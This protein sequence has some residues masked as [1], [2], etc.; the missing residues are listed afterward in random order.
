MLTL[1]S[2]WCRYTFQLQKCS[3]WIVHGVDITFNFK[4]AHIG[5]QAQ[6]VKINAFPSHS[7]QNEPRGMDRPCMWKMEFSFNFSF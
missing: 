4:S 5:Y 3:H 6:A 7:I 1:N 2:P